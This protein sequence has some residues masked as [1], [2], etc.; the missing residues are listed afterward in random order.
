MLSLSFYGKREKLNFTIQP[1]REQ[2]TLISLQQHDVTK[3]SSYM[4]TW[5][6]Q[7]RSQEEPTVEEE[8]DAA[9]QMGL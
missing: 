3:L 4:S 8:P 1:H 2:V 9:C 5:V 7:K 6:W